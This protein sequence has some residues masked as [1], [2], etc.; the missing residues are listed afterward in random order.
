RR[1]PRPRPRLTRPRL[2]PPA[3]PW[4]RMEPTASWPL[5]G[6][7]PE[8]GDRVLSAEAEAVDDRGVDLLL[9]GHE[10]RVV[11]VALGVRNP[12]VRGGW[13]HVLA[14][15]PDRGEPADHAGGAQEVA[16]HRLG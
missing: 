1:R 4:P 8:H 5:D 11:Q 6:E 10:R 15:R 14:D 13:H 12:Q 16:D 3:R 9:A 7:A 2:T